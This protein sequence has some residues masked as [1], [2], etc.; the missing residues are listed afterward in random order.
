MQSPLTDQW[1]QTFLD[2]WNEMYDAGL[3]Q[4]V[5]VVRGH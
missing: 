2:N 5:P 1:N 4:G 3:M